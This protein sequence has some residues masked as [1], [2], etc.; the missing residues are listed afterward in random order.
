MRKIDAMAN[1]RLKSQAIKV[2]DRAR[3]LAPVSTGALKD[4][5]TTWQIDGGVQIGSDLPYA[6]WVEVGGAQTTAQPYLRP[7]LEVLNA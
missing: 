4:S 6:Y 1:E 2:E 7:S 3:E 5:I